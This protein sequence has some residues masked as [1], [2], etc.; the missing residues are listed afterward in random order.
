MLGGATRS[1]W[2]LAALS[3][4]FAFLSLVSIRH[5]GLLAASLL[6][7]SQLHLAVAGEREEL[8][9]ADTTTAKNSVDNGGV[10]VGA[11]VERPH[12]VF[13]LIDDQGFNDMGPN[14]TDLSWATPR[15]EELARGGVRLTRYYTMHLCTPARAALLTGKYPHHTGMQ[16]SMISANEPW[17]LPLDEILAPEIARRRG[18]RSVMVGKWHLGHYK[19]AYTPLRRGFDEFF[20]FFSGFQDHFSHVS[21]ITC[22]D[23]DGSGCWYDLRDGRRPVTGREGEYTLFAL[24][25]EARRIVADY[26]AS[27]APLFLYF[28]AST[29]HMPVEPPTEVIQG[30]FAARLRQI[31]N[32]RRRAF[33]AATVAT[34]EVAGALVDALRSKGMWNLTVFV[35]ASD[36]GAQPQVI[37]A[38][39]NYPLRGMKGYYFEG[40]VRTHALIHSRLLGIDD[41]PSRSNAATYD[42][43][44]SVVDWLPTLFGPQPGIDGVDHWA[45]LVAA[46]KA[47]KPP[48]AARSSVV[49]NV[50]LVVCDANATAAECEAGASSYA[51]GALILNQSF[52]LL[53]N[54]QWLPVW[55][56]P[57]TDDLLRNDTY[58][59]WFDS[60]VEDFVFDLDNDPTETTNLRTSRP[61]LY[62][63]LRQ[64]FQD[65]LDTAVLPVY[66]PYSDDARA[67]A[68]F[69]DTKFLGPWLL[70]DENDDV[71][72]ACA[73][74]RDIEATDPILAN[75]PPSTP[76]AVPTSDIR[77]HRLDFFP[78]AVY[79]RY[80]LLPAASPACAGTAS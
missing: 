5:D 38:G 23:L 21:E 62:D 26:D 69:N 15:L 3:G 16:H 66:C 44:F 73:R 20:G 13:F 59:D 72:R 29:V 42:G 53:R 67:K 19:E 18:Y 6:P 61:E 74:D 78:T 51:T 10:G 32:A 39:S 50:D 56:V 80:E 2:K 48:P 52:K 75:R 76:A 43:L 9:A 60:T 63:A 41:D 22:C 70:D 35:C 79:C 68:A 58:F 27:S 46:A 40:G 64:A 17:G 31:P 30:K 11:A 49:V 71:T 47:A 45:H 1:R 24:R 28:A 14:S 12:V 4:L 55:P 77:Q 54:V 34:D 7:Q 25:D 33:A 8:A 65:A 37:A 36:N 57:K